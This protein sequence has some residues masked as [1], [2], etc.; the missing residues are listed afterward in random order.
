MHEGKESWSCSCRVGR[1][2]LPPP[3]PALTSPAR[4][5]TRPCLVRPGHS[6]RSKESRHPERTHH[7]VGARIRFCFQRY[8]IMNIERARLYHRRDD[9]GNILVKEV[10]DTSETNILLT[11]HE[12]MEKPPLT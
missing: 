9:L 2:R 1:P 4:R 6:H 10:R 3:A 8:D 5:I 12:F 11:V 7:Q